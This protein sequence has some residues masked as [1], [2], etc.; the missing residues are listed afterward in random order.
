MRAIEK[1]SDV[2]S[3]DIDAFSGF[4]AC[5]LYSTMQTVFRAMLLDHWDAINTW[6]GSH[7]ML[8]VADEYPKPAIAAPQETMEIIRPI[9]RSEPTRTDRLNLALANTFSIK[10]TD[11]PC[12][13]F[14]TSFTDQYCITYS[15]RQRD[16]IAAAFLELFQDCSNVWS[17]GDGN[18]REDLAHRRYLKLIELE[19]LLNRRKF[20]RRISSISKH[21]AFTALLKVY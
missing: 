15:F 11:M 16:D 3:E 9:G 18:R 21:P 6:S 17:T 20:L 1:L 14:F 12:V 19:P 8:L 4:L 10:I 7:L 5:I 2:T 13:V